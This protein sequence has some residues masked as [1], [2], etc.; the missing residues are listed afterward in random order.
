MTEPTQAEIKDAEK[1]ISASI[2]ISSKI[3]QFLEDEGI[4]MRMAVLSMGIAFA[5]G[6]RVSGMSLPHAIDLVRSTYK[7]GSHE[8]H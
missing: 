8:T 2:E 4:D 3:I 1:Q 7:M 6:A 5:G